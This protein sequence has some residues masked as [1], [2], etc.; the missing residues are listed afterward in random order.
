MAS[1]APRQIPVHRTFR[2][3]PGGNRN[4]GT[5]VADRGEVVALL[6]EGVARCDETTASMDR[7]TRAETSKPMPSLAVLMEARTVKRRH[8]VDVRG[9]RMLLGQLD[10]GPASA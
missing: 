3:L 8:E 9:L 4:G 2:V 7:I 5:V 1:T 10:R 6:M